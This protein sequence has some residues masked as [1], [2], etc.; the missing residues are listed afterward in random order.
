MTIFTLP[1]LRLAGE[2]DVDVVADVV[3]DAFDHLGVIQWLVPDPDRRWQVSRAWYRLYAEHAIGGAGQVVLTEDNTACAVWFDR[4]GPVSEP[5]D[6]ASR[7]AQLAGK[8]L[9]RFEHLDAQMDTHH[10][11][12]PHWHLL[13]LAVRPGQWGQGLG[14]HLM[15]YTH[16]QLDAHGI[17]AYLEAT[18][19]DNA[20]L[21]RRHHYT[22]MD[23]FD[24]TVDDDVSLYRMWR[25]PQPLT[26]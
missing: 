17:P 25:A 3:A 20:R 21:Y 11:K 9:D 19:A 2:A 15:N 14:S 22:N 13:F 8:H 6:Y 18:N 7:L 4:T 24:L 23:P 16:N 5:D 26:A 12:P 1:E 10:P